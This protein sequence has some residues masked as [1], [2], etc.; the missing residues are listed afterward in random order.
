MDYLPDDKKV[1]ILEELRRQDKL[2]FITL[3]NSSKKWKEIC[4]NIDW[5]RIYKQDFGKY[6]KS[7]NITYRQAYSN[8]VNTITYLVNNGYNVYFCIP[9]DQKYTYKSLVI[10]LEEYNNLEKNNI[11]ANYNSIYVRDVG[12]DINSDNIKFNK[13]KHYPRDINKE[14]VFKL[15]TSSYSISNLLS[16]FVCKIIISNNIV[17]ENKLNIRDIISDFNYSVDHVS[18][19]P[20]IYQYTY[21]EEDLLYTVED[22]DGDIS[23]RQEYI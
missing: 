12:K 17:N 20:N 2:G 5:E 13:S 22:F 4:D 15:L 1:E 18:N 6:K 16:N 10:W 9:L 7:T 21:I 23:V 19:D 14:L 11:E 3:C 8:I